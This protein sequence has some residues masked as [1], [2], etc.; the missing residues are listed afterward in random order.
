[1]T[2]LWFEYVWTDGFMEGNNYLCSSWTILD[3]GGIDRPMIFYNQQMPATEIKT[4]EQH[5]GEFFQI[6][7]M[8]AAADENG[9]RPPQGTY[10][11]D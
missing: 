5:P 2:G 8:W 4:D 11:R 10:D 7:M 6:E 3:N 9:V 1:M